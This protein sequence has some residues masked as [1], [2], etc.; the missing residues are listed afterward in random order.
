MAETG[1][2]VTSKTLSRLIPLAILVYIQT[3]SRDLA[4]VLVIFST[5]TGIAMVVVI[6]KCPFDNL[7]LICFAF[8]YRKKV[9]ILCNQLKPTNIFD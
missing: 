6:R 4:P 2:F 3:F 5:C 9:E 7:L 8:V 1:N